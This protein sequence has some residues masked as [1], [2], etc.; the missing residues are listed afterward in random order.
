[1]EDEKKQDAVQ[2]I[3]EDCT[4]CKTCAESCRI[5]NE[6]DEEPVSIASRGVD[7]TEAFSCALC[8]KCEAVCSLGL[9]PYRMFEQRR[10]EAVANHEI[11]VNEYRYLFPDREN[12][13]MSAFREY[14]DVKYP[15]LNMSLPADMAFLPGCT[16]VTYSPRLTRKVYDALLEL[17]HNI[18]LL[19]D[20]CGL[21]MY[22]IGLPER[23]DKIKT[24]L[25]SKVSR[26]GV[27]RIVVA[28]PNCYYQLRKTS[29]FK[30]I[31]IITVYEAL[32][33]IF[34]SNRVNGI[35]TVHDSCPDRF[36]GIFAAQVIPTVRL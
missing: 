35:Y 22:Q 29:I 19:N 24:R 4:G 3:I 34:P 27:K 1:M 6:I 28:C 21:P 25:K 15:D 16:M 23:G 17:H 2:K 12:N 30:N 11:D 36:D 26:L 14:Y 8:G 33:D 13:V 18:V 20:C 5:L 10:V 32:K 7:W 9:S 31:E